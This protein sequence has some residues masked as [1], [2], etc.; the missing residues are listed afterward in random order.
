MIRS[1]VQRSSGWAKYIHHMANA[2][3]AAG[4]A[5]VHQP[6]A[7]VML[8]QPL[9]STRRQLPCSYQSPS[10]MRWCG[11][12]SSCRLCTAGRWVWP[13]ITVTLRNGFKIKVVH[14]RIDLGD[15]ATAHELLPRLYGDLAWLWPLLTI[16][17][18]GAFTM[19]RYG[20]GD[21]QLLKLVTLLSIGV[22]QAG[23]MHYFWQHPKDSEKVKIDFDSN[24]ET[25]HLEQPERLERLREHEPDV[26]LWN[27]G[28][29]QALQ[30]ET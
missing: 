23:L 10:T 22:V 19:I 16:P 13:W 6:R 1:R 25:N 24:H 18:L 17:L 8:V 7:R 5:C 30:S 4:P 3:R 2:V 28:T 27:T 11:T 12:P 15:R 14:A 29:D 21:Y 20:D 26:L 9:A